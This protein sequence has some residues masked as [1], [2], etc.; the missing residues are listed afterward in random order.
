M[1]RA[2]KTD[3]PVVKADVT[4]KEEA[5]KKA[6]KTAKTVKA[7]TKKE[8]KKSVAK[9]AA[10]KTVKPVKAVSVAKTAKPVKKAK[11][12][13]SDL[14]KKLDKEIS[15]IASKQAEQAVFDA[16]VDHIRKLAKNL[17]LA[18]EKAAAALGIT[19]KNRKKYINAI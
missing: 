2:K 15:T 13:Y 10:E 14:Y 19:P 6:E 18:P 9:P 11:A 16:T 3:A 1:A 5:V 8:V 17:K 4:V 12:D 7:G